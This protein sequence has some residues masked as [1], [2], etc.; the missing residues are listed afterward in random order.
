MNAHVK[1]QEAQFAV[2][3]LCPTPITLAKSGAAWVTRA[4]ATR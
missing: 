1:I 2:R 4:T 3:A